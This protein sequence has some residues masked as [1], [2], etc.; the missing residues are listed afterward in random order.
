MNI[1]IKLDKLSVLN[2]DEV[3]MIHESTM[4][5]MSTIGVKID[6]EDARL[7]LQEKGAQFDDKTKFIKI[8]EN[9][10]N[11]LLKKVPNKFSL[12]GP[13][14]SFKVEVNTHSMNFA[15]FGA[16]VNMYDPS[17]KKGI[18]KSTLNDAIDHIRVVNGLK[19]IVSKDY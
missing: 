14:G 18:R 3:L 7:L 15:T 9:L 10:I 12:Y 2:D 5:L 11:D 13:D 17:K 16:A 4:N 19:N 1:L 6:S 8:P